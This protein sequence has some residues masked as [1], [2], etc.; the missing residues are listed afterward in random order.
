MYLHADATGHGAHNGK[1][2]L[3][4][5]R[6]EDQAVQKLMLRLSEVNFNIYAM[7]VCVNCLM[8]ACSVQVQMQTTSN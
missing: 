2:L 1:T 8:C 3:R 7:C 4:Q 5:L 6:A